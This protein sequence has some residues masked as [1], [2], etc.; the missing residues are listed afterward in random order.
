MV[1]K[2]QLILTCAELTV[3]TSLSNDCNTSVFFN[4][5]Q[6]LNSTDLALSTIHIKCTW[7]WPRPPQT[8]SNPYFLYTL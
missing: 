2:I 7:E 1:L 3:L 8:K 5:K 6:I 4:E